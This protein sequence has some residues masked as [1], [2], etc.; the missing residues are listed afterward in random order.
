MYPKAQ[1][2]TGNCYKAP[3]VSARYTAVLYLIGAITAG[4]W[5]LRGLGCPDQAPAVYRKIPVYRDWTQIPIPGFLKIKYR[6][7]SGFLYSMCVLKLPAREDAKSHWL[8]LFGFFL[9]CAFSCVSSNGLPERMQSHIGYICLT[10]PHCACSC[11]S[12]NCLPERM[13]S[14]IGCICFTSGQL[15]YAIVETL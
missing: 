6:Y 13:Q 7:F 12:S 1:S 4:L 14:H 3:S 11:V 9:H 8:H 10:F 15:A 5:E 2:R